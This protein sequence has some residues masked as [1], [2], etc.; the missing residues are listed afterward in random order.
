LNDPRP[1]GTEFTTESKDILNPEKRT[2]LTWRVT[3]RVPVSDKDEVG[4]EI[5]M[6]IKEEPINDGEATK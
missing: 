2:R 5:L 6:C 3:G 4:R 1:I